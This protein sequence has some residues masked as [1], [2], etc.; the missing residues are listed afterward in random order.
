M[1]GRG[2]CSNES[3]EL[4]GFAIFAQAAIKLLNLGAMQRPRLSKHISRMTG[5]SEPPEQ[6]SNRR[7]QTAIS[8]AAQGVATF[9]GIQYWCLM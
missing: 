1:G 4:T 2:G 6:P 8:Q 3:G 5:N 7:K 9:R